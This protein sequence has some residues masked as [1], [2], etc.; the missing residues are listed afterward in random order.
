MPD[1]L[2]LRENTHWYFAEMAREF[3][4]EH[5]LVWDM[6][7]YLDDKEESLK[8]T[9]VSLERIDFFRR[10]GFEVIPLI[11]GAYE[12]H[13]WISASQIREWEFDVAAF[14]V[15]EY[16]SASEKPWP[17]ID[18]YSLTAEDLMIRYI[19]VILEYDFSQ[20]LLVGGGSPRYARRLLELDDRICLAG[21]SWYL[22]GVK[23]NLY[24]PTGHVKPLG[25]RW[26]ECSCLNC[27]ST[28]PKVLK[29][30]S[31]IAGHNL[32]LNKLLVEDL[33]TEDIEVVF[34]GLI[35]DYHENILVVGEVSVGADKSI[36][37]ALTR[38]LYR[39]KPD[40]LIIIGSIFDWGAVD[41]KRLGEWIEFIEALKKL[42]LDYGVELIPVYRYV[43]KNLPYLMT[44]LS[45]TINMR[46][47][48]SVFGESELDKALGI[49]TRIISSSRTP[50]KIKKKV[51]PERSIVFTVEYLGVAEKPFEAAAED[52]KN[53]RRHGDW[54]IT[55]YINQPYIDHEHQ[56]ATPGVWD[57]TWRH[58]NEPKPGAIHITKEG[59]I[60]LIKLRD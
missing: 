16:L 49:I 36:W 43:G 29:T 6:P 12:E 22:D 53:L 25:N 52:L 10:E 33:D 46:P 51:D 59:E 20:L 57:L 60:M 15:S 27:R 24:M 50:I 30:T 4:I 32:Y 47:R 11:K 41:N 35:A 23:N 7:T 44:N 19:E 42:H 55:D 39:V 21:Y 14:H 38:Y 2:L 13:I 40:Y 45:F 17:Q 58:Y 5:V 34:Y 37:R 3:G 8:N 18:N 28:P 48:G 1:D 56:V 31:Y 54:L 26:F 9:Y